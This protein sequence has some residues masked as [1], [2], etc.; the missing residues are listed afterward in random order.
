MIPADYSGQLTALLRYSTPQS[1]STFENVP[2]HTVLLLRQALALQM[3]PNP[4][5]GAATV[6]ENR[7]LLNI[8]SDVPPPVNKQRR[9][10][11]KHTIAQEHMTSPAS[12]G[13]SRQGTSFQMG[14]PEMLARGLLER[15]ESLGI[16]KTL[17]SAVS[18]LRVSIHYM[19]YQCNSTST[20]HS[21]T[22]PIW[23][24]RSFGHLMRHILHFH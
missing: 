13:H 16:N 9:T 18:E 10:Q 21:V 2:H 6:L 23:L 1:P 15:G 8:P 17:M 12:Q 3:S 22:S 11:T 19:F 14:L 7:G 20:T 4:S 24:P 5:T